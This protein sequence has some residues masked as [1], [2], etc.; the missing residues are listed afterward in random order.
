GHAIVPGRNEHID[1]LR[2]ELAEYFEGGCTQFSVSLT[3]PGT[4]FQRRVWEEL[5]QIPHGE[6]RSYE[7]LARGI[8][9]PEAVRGVGRANGQNRIAILIPCHRVVNKNGQ[10]GGYGG[11]VWR[12]RQLLELERGQANGK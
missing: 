1:R 12:K 3:Y 4:P 8:G 2:R 7:E 11:G 9:S 10:L 6:T 5:L